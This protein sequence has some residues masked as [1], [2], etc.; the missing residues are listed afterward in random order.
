MKIQ[1][2]KEKQQF[3]KGI[4]GIT[5]CAIVS[6]EVQG[7][8]GRALW[9][10]ASYFLSFLFIS[11]PWHTPWALMHHQHQL[12]YD[13]AWYPCSW[14]M[15]DRC[16]C[17]FKKTEI[18]RLD[19]ES[20]LIVGRVRASISVEENWNSRCCWPDGAEIRGGNLNWSWIALNFNLIL[21]ESRRELE[22]IARQRVDRCL[23]LQP[24]IVLVFL[25]GKRVY[26]VPTDVLFYSRGERFLLKA[27]CGKLYVKKK[28]KKKNKKSS[29]LRMYT[30]TPSKLHYAS[31]TTKQRNYNRTHSKWR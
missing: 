2:G 23:P 30:K 1:G 3:S 7:W 12:G 16:R 31:I 9:C 24:R 28:K 13:P 21:L 18:R 6:V 5:D 29:S 22:T 10:I 25:K 14:Q 4:Q 20:C 17:W 11:R 27:R 15:K 19:K 8:G 26:D